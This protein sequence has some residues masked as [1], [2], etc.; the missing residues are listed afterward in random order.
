M[1]IVAVIVFCLAL[2][3]LGAEFGWIAAGA[4]ARLRESRV[5]SQL[6]WET[7]NACRTVEGIARQARDDIYGLAAEGLSRRQ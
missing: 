4:V 6:A 1:F 3:G 7:S 5:R 2:V